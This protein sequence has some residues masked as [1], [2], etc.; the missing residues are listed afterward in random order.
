MRAQEESVDVDEVVHPSSLSRRATWSIMAL[1]RSVG[2]V[3]KDMISKVLSF[4][5]VGGR[6][7]LNVYWHLELDRQFI[8]KK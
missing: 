1:M 8:S 3:G 2:M 5:L 7:S 4:C 6:G